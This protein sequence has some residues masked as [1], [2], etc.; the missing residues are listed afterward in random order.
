MTC[1]VARVGMRRL[2]MISLLLCALDALG[3]SA[4]SFVFALPLRSIS[5]APQCGLAVVT[6]LPTMTSITP[7][8]AF[9]FCLQMS[10]SRPSRSQAS[11]T[12]T[13]SRL[14]WGAD[15]HRTSLLAQHDWAEIPSSPLFGVLG[16]RY[17]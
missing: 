11:L 3:S 1:A 10:S 13:S 16:C 7:A 6:R 4:F 8:T 15:S 14:H 17:K 12:W 5:L 9:C 2:L